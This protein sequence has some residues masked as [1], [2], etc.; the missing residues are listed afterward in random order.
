MSALELRRCRHPRRRSCCVKP[1]T[2]SVTLWA[3]GGRS[4]ERW[5]R[6][7]RT[8]SIWERS[9][10]FTHSLRTA[11]SS[12][13]RRFVVSPAAAYRADCQ[14]RAEPFGRHDDAWITAASLLREAAEE[15]GRARRGSLFEAMRIAGDA[16][17]DDA[18]E[19]AIRR[20][21]DGHRSYIDSLF[22]LAD[23]AHEAGATRL[24]VTMLDDLL[25][26]AD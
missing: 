6:R 9:F 14:D 16:L 4:W 21:W 26:A 8:H 5:R 3:I 1:S 18:I 25:L 10:I 23:R 13:P 15:S 11:S 7:A 22:V 12:S 2:D 24:A 20:N 17:G 19:T